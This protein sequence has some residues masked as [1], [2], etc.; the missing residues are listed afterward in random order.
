MKEEILVKL[1]ELLE[2]NQKIIQEVEKLLKIEPVEV[3]EEQDGKVR[4]F[5]PEAGVHYRNED[6]QYHREDG[7]ALI[8]KSG[9]KHWYINGQLHRDDGPAIEYANGTREWYINGVRFFSST[10]YRSVIDKTVTLEQIDREDSLERRRLFIDAYGIEKYVLNTKSKIVAKNGET[11]I[12]RNR[13]KWNDEPIVLIKLKNSTPEPD[14]SYKYYFLRI[15]P[16]FGRRSW[17]KTDSEH[18]KDAIAWTFDME[19]KQYN[20]AIES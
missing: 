15:P 17:L 12:Y 8:H 2:T 18:I 4:K 11:V 20:P 10:D 6:G 19:G 16:R 9:N 14:G 5:V 3:V 1:K 13:R 7:P